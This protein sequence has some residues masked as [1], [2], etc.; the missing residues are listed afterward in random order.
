MVDSKADQPR[1]YVASP[2]P[3]VMTTAQLYREISN[4]ETRLLTRLGA[5]EKAMELAHDDVVRVPTLL[6]RAVLNLREYLLGEIRK[7]EAVSDEK[8][9]SVQTQFT[10]RDTRT[11]QTA[12]DSKVTVDIA[13]KAQQEAFG[14]QN[15]SFAQAVAKSEANT[16]KQ[17]DQIG[18]L[19]SAQTKATNDK[20][21][22]LK[23]RLGAIE[24]RAKGSNDNWSWIVGT[25]GL[26]VAA[27]ALIATF[28]RTGVGN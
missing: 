28:M 3:S 19:I 6:D 13:L 24:G 5:L 14:G 9:N 2:D 12:R 1:P 16:T 18:T 25:G 7:L 23:G 20:I 21:D 27:V 17:I 15:K 10:E 11:E 4:L 22:D 8:F 26:L